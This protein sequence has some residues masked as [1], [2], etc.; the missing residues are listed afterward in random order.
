MEGGEKEKN[1]K[2]EIQALI[3]VAR[4]QKKKKN[5]EKK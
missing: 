3:L 1:R 2:T 5:S 4:N